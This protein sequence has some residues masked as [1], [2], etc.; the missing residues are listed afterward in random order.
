AVAATEPRRVLAQDL[1]VDSRHRRHWSGHHGAIL[2]NHCLFLTQ[3]PPARSAGPG[4][5]AWNGR[6]LLSAA[7]CSA[8]NNAGRV[9]RVVSARRRLGGH[10]RFVVAAPAVL[11]T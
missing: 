8:R 10:C 4:D 9:Y 2:S 3:T 5:A 11:R 7:I 1:M 6:I